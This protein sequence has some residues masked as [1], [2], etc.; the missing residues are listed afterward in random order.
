MKLEKSRRGQQKL[1]QFTIDAIHWLN[2]GIQSVQANTSA[3]HTA[4][5]AQ[6]HS[7]NN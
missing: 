5:P 4:Y 3:G 1:G 6:P 7:L 2:E